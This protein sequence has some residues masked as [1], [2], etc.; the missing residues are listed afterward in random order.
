MCI[1]DS[2]T[3]AQGMIT[4]GISKISAHLSSLVLLIQA[5]AAAL[6][7]WLL[8]SESILPFQAI[9]GFIVLVAIYLAARNN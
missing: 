7:G 2:Q 4:Y 6:Y 9:G 8:L 1:R 3:I 5:L